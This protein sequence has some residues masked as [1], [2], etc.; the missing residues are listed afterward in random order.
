MQNCKSFHYNGSGLWDDPK[1]NLQEQQDNKKRVQRDAR[2]EYF[3]DFK[4]RGRH[5]ELSSH[6]N[7]FSM[8]E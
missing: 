8:A 1:D 7:L 5:A 2:L 6:Q 4:K 3:V